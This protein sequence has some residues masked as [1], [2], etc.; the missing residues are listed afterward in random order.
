MA[1]VMC[2]FLMSAC[3]ATKADA[4]EGGK[5]MLKV[6]P[7][8]EVTYDGNGLVTELVGINED[9][10][11]IVANYSKYIGREC[12]IVM[13]ELVSEIKAAGYFVEEVEGIG[14]QITIEIEEGSI[15]PTDSFMAE[16]VDAIKG[17][18]DA[19]AMNSKLVVKGEEIFEIDDFDDDIDDDDDDDDIDDD[20]DDDIDDEDDDDDID[21]EDDDIDDDDDDIDDDEDEDDDDIDDDDDDDEDD[22]DDDDDE[23]DDDDDDDEE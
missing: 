21:D 9:G 22:D 3:G 5:L 11:A 10:K 16:I 6:N 1:L 20:E 19:E 14:K 17:Y 15:Q 12:K 8:I 23:D 7:E 2:F 18:V 4:S 13:A